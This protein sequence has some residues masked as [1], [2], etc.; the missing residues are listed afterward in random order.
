MLQVG[1]KHYA[2]RTKSAKMA[3]SFRKNLWNGKEGTIRQEQVKPVKSQR[4]H[5]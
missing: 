4:S 5:S 1:G 2:I 3:V